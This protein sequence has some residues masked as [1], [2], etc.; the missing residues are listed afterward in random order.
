MVCIEKEHKL[1]ESLC[2]KIYKKYWKR[3]DSYYTRQ[4][5]GFQLIP[6]SKT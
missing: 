3:V 2:S 1:R 4:A 5:R 6:A